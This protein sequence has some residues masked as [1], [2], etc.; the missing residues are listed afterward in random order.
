MDTFCVPV[1][2][3]FRS[4]RKMA[5]NSMAEIFSGADAVLVLDPEL[6]KLNYHEMGPEQSFAHVIR[7]SWMSRCWTL[8]EASLSK[9]WHVQFNDSVIDMLKTV[10]HRRT[11]S[12]VKFLA[13]RG[14]VQP[15]LQRAFNEE[16]SNFLMEMGE[17][18]YQRRGRYDRSEIWNLKQL[19]SHQA[20]VFATT[21]NNFLGQTTS[22]LE[23][24]HQI[25][26][27]LEDM[28]VADVRDLS[29]EDRMKA[30]L[31]CHVSL[32]TDLLFCCCERMHDEG[33]VNTWA[34]KIPA[35]QRLDD[36]FG[37]MKIFTD[38]LYISKEEASEH[39]RFYLVPSGGFKEDKFQFEIP[40]K[41]KFWVEMYPKRSSQELHLG[42]GV[43]CLGFPIRSKQSGINVS[44]DS[45]GARFSLRESTGDDL[46]LSYNGSFRLYAY[47]R[48]AEGIPPIERLCPLLE[49][50]TNSNRVFID[51]GES[52]VSRHH[53][54]WA[55]CRTFGSSRRLARRTSLI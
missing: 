16:V 4:A 17:V 42:N 26:A 55:Y 5:I 6:R 34:P 44:L 13:G 38:C 9:S 47:D 39:L 33:A 52:S 3:T 10:E 20:Y 43:L 14:K 51:C 22:K 30:I 41:E 29:I 28:R 1:G 8:L 21:W 48:E 32:P 27:A 54:L 53:V 49:P 18:R 36:S 37:T 45:R 24:L 2:Q 40:K 12:K 19:E 31:K 35:G 25:L 23:D 11:R 15:S 46:R 50:L 7:S